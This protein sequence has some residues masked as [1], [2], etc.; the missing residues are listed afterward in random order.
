MDGK[1]RMSKFQRTSQQNP[2][3]FAFCFEVWRCDRGWQC[4][5]AAQRSG[6]LLSADSI[7]NWHIVD[8]HDI[9]VIIILLSEYVIIVTKR[10]QPRWIKPALIAFIIDT[11]SQT[12]R[13]RLM[14]R[15]KAFKSMF[16]YVWYFYMVCCMNIVNNANKSTKHA[17]DTLEAR[18]GEK[19]MKGASGSSQ[20]M[21]LLIERTVI[22]F[23]LQ[24]SM[25]FGC[26]LLCTT[27]S[28]DFQSRASWYIHEIHYYTIHFIN[29]HSVDLLCYRW[30]WMKLEILN[31]T[32]DS[33]AYQLSSFLMFHIKTIIS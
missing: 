30:P 21:N 18:C 12:R 17:R 31:F 4:L 19:R 11:K 32:S 9:F 2:E 10:S 14:R 8:I 15:P 24:D 23:R 6:P 25:W 20:D 13:R 28:L 16:R 1:D 27:G 7:G 29:L 3:T 33:S 5:E 22:V 26:A